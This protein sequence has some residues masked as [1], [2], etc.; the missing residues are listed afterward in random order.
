MVSLQRSFHRSEQSGAS[1]LRF[2]EIDICIHLT[3][4]SKLPYSEVKSVCILV[5]PGSVADA[6]TKNFRVKILSHDL[7]QYGRLCPLNRPKVIYQ[8]LTVQIIQMTQWLEVQGS[9]DNRPK[10]HASQLHP[11]AASARLQ[12]RV[13]LLR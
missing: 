1:F 7:P 9:L 13:N 4:A 5:W 3:S 11:S 12:A 2:W 10:L 8:M 6:P